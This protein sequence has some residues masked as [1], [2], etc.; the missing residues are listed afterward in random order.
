MRLAKTTPPRGTLWAVSGREVWRYGL[1]F[2][3]LIAGIVLAK[4][5]ETFCF[6]GGAELLSKWWAPKA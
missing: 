5:G 4:G 1:L 6:E 3:L 2:L